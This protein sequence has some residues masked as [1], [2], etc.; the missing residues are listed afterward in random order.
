MRSKSFFSV[1][2]RAT[3]SLFAALALSFSAWAQ[4]QP[5]E[6]SWRSGQLLLATGDTVS[7]S[8]TLTLPNDIVRVTQPNG[9]ISAFSAVN[10][11]SFLVEHEQ[12]SGLSRHTEGPLTFKREYQSFLWNHDK[13]YSNFK[14][15]AF[16]AV[17]Q[18]GKN[19]LLMREIKERY[20]DNAS[21]SL[22][23]NSRMERER[24]REKFYLLL[25]NQEIKPLR[26]PKKDLPEIY[27]KKGK[28]ILTF[29]KENKL[30]FTEPLELARIVNYA[31]SLL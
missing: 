4:E 16:F 30:S 15:P 21:G 18:P 14:S 1:S 22:Y 12:N 31:N 10:V 26:N 29:A 9:A 3:L 19:T 17:L 11:K 6:L 2:G 7:G 27:G 24:I 8:V 25:P 5:F 23:S 28:Q 13:D 20:Y